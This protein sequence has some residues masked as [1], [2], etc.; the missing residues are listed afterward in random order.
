VPVS[1]LATFLLQI[2]SI[3]PIAATMLVLA[4]EKTFHR[5]FSNLPELTPRNSTITVLLIEHD[6]GNYQYRNISKLV[7]SGRG[8]N[9]WIC[10]RYQGNILFDNM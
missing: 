2:H 1:H 8:R 4:N 10:C 6:S 7:V 3:F 5:H 9:W